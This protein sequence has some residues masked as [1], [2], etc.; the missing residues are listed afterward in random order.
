M[1]TKKHHARGM[2]FKIVDKILKRFIVLGF[3]HPFSV[4]ENP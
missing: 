3:C 1:D 4:I 2:A